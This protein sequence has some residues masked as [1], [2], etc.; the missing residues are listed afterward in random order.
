[1]IVLTSREGRW[2]LR[3]LLGQLPPEAERLAPGSVGEGI[4]TPFS[5][6]PVGGP[7]PEDRVFDVDAGTIEFWFRPDWAPTLPPYGKTPKRVFL[8]QGPYRWEHPHTINHSSVVL[9]CTDAL[10]FRFHDRTYRQRAVRAPLP[11]HW[12]DGQFHHIALQWRNRDGALDMAV[13]VD[14][15]KRSGAVDTRG[16]ENRFRK[17]QESFPVVIGSDNKG[18]DPAEGVFHQFRVSG[19]PRYDEPFT[20]PETMEADEQ[21]TLFLPTAGNRKG[22]AP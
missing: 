3:R 19:S 22:A 14:G 15:R 5:C 13:F 10:S 4:P 1:D 16:D 17:E 2:S 20:P 11:E 12:L 18:I 7:D 21:T 6:A 8:H 9:E